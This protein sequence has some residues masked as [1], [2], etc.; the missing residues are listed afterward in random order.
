[1]RIFISS[2]FRD[3][4]AERDAVVEALRCDWVAENRTCTG[5]P[6]PPGIANLDG[7]K[8]NRSSLCGRSLI[9]GACNVPNLLT[10]AFRIEL[11]RAA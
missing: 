5:P 6:S 1:M 11:I 8:V 4:R 9:A 10:V 7:C 3:L 2:T